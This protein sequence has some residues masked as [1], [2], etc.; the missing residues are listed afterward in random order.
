MSTL[1]PCAPPA[2]HLVVD[3][4]LAIL[5][6]LVPDE[7]E[8]IQEVFDALSDRSRYL[9]FHAATPR[10]T[11]TALRH[12]ARV[13]ACER[14]AVVAMIGARAVG[15]AQWARYADEPHVAEL[16]VAVG[17]RF[18]QRGIGRALVATAAGG[19]VR[20]GVAH[21]R[22]HGPPREQDRPALDAGR[23][24]RTATR[25]C[26]RAPR[27][28]GRAGPIPGRPAERPAHRLR[29]TPESRHRAGRP[30]R[31][32]R[33][34]RRALH[35]V[36]R[37]VVERPPVPA[38]VVADV[39][40]R[41]PD[42]HRGGS[43]ARQPVDPRAVAAEVAAVG[44]RAPTVVGV[45][46]HVHAV[47][48]R[49][50]VAADRQHLART[51]GGQREHATG[52]GGRD[53]G[54]R[55]RPGV[56]AVAGVEHPGRAA[57][58]GEVDV[59]PPGRHQAG[60]AG[61]EPELA[62]DGVGHPGRVHDRPGGAAVGGLDDPELAVD[63]VAHRQPAL[64]AGPHRHAVV[65]GVRVVVH[66]RLGPGPAA[67]GGAED[68][69]VARLPDR[70]HQDVTGP[71]DLDVAQQQAGG[72]GG[73]HVGPGLA[74]VVGLPDAALAAA[75]PRVPAVGGVQPAELLVGVDAD[76]V[77]GRLPMAVPTTGVRRAGRAGGDEQQ[78]GCRDPEKSAHVPTLTRT[79]HACPPHPTRPLP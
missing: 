36:V 56:P 19:V 57:A 60:A 65:E 64:A 66:E 17:D 35:R 72:V 54:V 21:D 9:R 13:V 61:R 31:P 43:R 75:D 67:V 11:G 58:R 76:R 37:R 38:A 5:R 12:L 53:G 16:A 10:L 68:P 77:P 55:H 28:G 49:R 63:R 48:G 79:S 24:R 25:P 4:G 23:R 71:E 45:R 44:P 70:H 73:R 26:G 22:G 1:A 20:A 74:A 32:A 42:R 29:V 39:A 51:A 15:V 59:V 18:Q 78:A 33:A 52:L 27:R 41:R 2:D 6:P 7:P 3:G 34:V 8:R 46:R 30:A 50:E 40:A 62:L 47:V 69:A 14:G